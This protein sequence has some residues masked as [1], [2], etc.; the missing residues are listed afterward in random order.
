M[1]SSPSEGIRNSGVSRRAR[2]RLVPSSAIIT[3]VAAAPNPKRVC[4]RFQKTSAKPIDWYQR[5]SV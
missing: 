2:K 4:S 5:T 3:T 1:T